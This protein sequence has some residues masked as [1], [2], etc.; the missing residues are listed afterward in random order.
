MKGW[1]ILIVLI[2]VAGWYLLS[3]GVPGGEA[4][5]ILAALKENRVGKAFVSVSGGKGLVRFE[6]PAINEDLLDY[7][8]SVAKTALRA[9]DVNVVRAEAYFEGDPI[10]A[11]T[12]YRGKEEDP[13]IE[14]IRSVERRV[15]SV[16]GLFDA[17]PIDTNVG[18][19]EARVTVQYYGNEGN[20]WRD[21][22]GMA[23]GIIEEAPWVERIV[24]TYVGE[25]NITV[26]VD[27]STVLDVYSGK[28]SADA[29]AGKISMQ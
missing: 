13:G 14:D 17:I 29:A 3:Y 16:V 8:H 9:S 10:V 15:E 11:V 6:A 20:F 26:T 24:V 1:I 5:K 4:G 2:A 23:L 7:T 25:K 21:F 28:I 22:F 19:D 12:V 18:N 27:A